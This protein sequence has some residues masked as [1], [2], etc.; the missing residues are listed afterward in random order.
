M[1]QNK[2]A[3]GNIE[4]LQLDAQGNTSED[5]VLEK[6]VLNNCWISKITPSE[7]DYDSEDLANIEI[8]LVYDWAELTTINP[9]QV[10]HVPRATSLTA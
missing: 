4:I 7:V 8:I 6:W 5:L 10:I 9:P 3:G 2:V 1:G